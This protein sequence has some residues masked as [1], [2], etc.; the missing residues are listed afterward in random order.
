MIELIKDFV[1]FIFYIYDGVRVGMYCLWYGIVK[2]S[3]DFVG[4]LC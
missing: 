4:Y 1:V 2:V 3:L